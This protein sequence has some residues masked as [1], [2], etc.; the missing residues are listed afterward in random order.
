MNENKPA[1][2]LM[3]IVD[4]DRIVPIKHGPP[5]KVKGPGLL[6]RI[7]AAKSVD[8]VDSLVREGSLYRGASI[9]TRQRWVRAAANRKV[10]ITAPAPQPKA[11]QPKKDKKPPK[12]K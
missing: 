9:R 10:A 12:P 7:H 5:N 8:E 2:E 3:R 6:A 4:K 11:E 1:P